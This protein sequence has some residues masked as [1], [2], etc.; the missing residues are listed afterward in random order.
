[1]EQIPIAPACPRTRAVSFR[2]GPCC[3]FRDV[4]SLPPHVTPTVPNRQYNRRSF[5]KVNGGS[6]PEPVRT[7]GVGAPPERLLVVKLAEIGDVLLIMPALK[8]LREGLPRTSIDVLTTAS[9]AAVLGGSGLYDEIILFDKHRFDTPRDLLRPVNL[10]YALQLGRKLH[11]R[12][13]DAVMLFHHL[14]TRFGSLK[15]AAFC[16]ATGAPRRLG[17][18][19][20]RG[21]FLDEAVQ[22]QGYGVHHELDYA[23]SVAR[24]LVPEAER[25]APTFAPSEQET[26]RAHALLAQ[27]RDGSGP[28]IALHPGSG[29]YAPARRWPAARF[30][31]LADHLIADGAQIV[32][33][34]GA[35]ER[36]LREAVLSQMRY[37]SGVTDLGGRTTLGELLAVL[38]Q[39]ELFV[40]ND[41]GVLHLAASAG[42]PV[43]APYGPTDP[44]AWGPWAPESWRCVR[45]Y[46]NGVEVLRSGPHTTLKAAIACSPCIY[47]GMGLGTPNGCPDRTCLERITVTQVLETV[48]DRLAELAASQVGA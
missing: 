13:Y 20:G 38:R 5:G 24:L 21:F 3:V 1:M 12:R 41:G 25:A 32:L 8:A 11:R 35:E 27:S 26:S 2:Y 44:H 7:L 37:V 10:W 4:P 36:T 39:C 48:R 29:V 6:M 40:G 23:L 22:D 34:G 18:D 33:L 15:Y 28:L 31:T 9:G 46:P 45:A 19:N 16:Y 47:R 42:T 30:A 14:A 43:V 17:L